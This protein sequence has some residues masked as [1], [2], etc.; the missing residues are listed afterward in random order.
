MMSVNACFDRPVRTSASMPRSEKMASAA[1]E[2]LSA[3]R[4][5]T[6]ASRSIQLVPRPVEPR[7]QR[8]DVVPVYGRPAPDAQSRRC[9]SMRRE[10]EGDPFV[11]E[12]GRKPAD[13]G[14]LLGYRKAREATVHDLE[15]YRGGRA[16]AFVCCVKCGP[17]GLAHPPRQRC[18]VLVCTRDECVEAAG[19]FRPG[20]GI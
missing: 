14:E 6:R 18:K 17:F 11:F 16:D 2:S 5:F 20:D 3:M 9:R 8:L 19:R 15:A 1:D 12:N 7:C 13:R 10:I 4:T